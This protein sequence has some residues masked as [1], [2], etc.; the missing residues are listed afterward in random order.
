[1]ISSHDWCRGGTALFFP[2]LN[3]HPALSPHCPLLPLWSWLA[4]WT[5][6]GAPDPSLCHPMKTRGGEGSSGH[7]TGLS[8]S[9]CQAYVPSPGFTQSPQR[10][11][12][13][14]PSPGILLLKWANH[15]FLPGWKTLDGS[16]KFTFNLK[17]QFKCHCFSALRAS[18]K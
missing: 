6:P 9:S 8:P 3:C 1:M 15:N 12:P 16:L 13:C 2:P 10:R 18:L 17:C 11:L 14:L 4:A 5:P 7:K